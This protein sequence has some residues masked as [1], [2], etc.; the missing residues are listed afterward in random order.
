MSIENKKFVSSFF[1]KSENYLQTNNTK[2]PKSITKAELSKEVKSLESINVEVPDNIIQLV[3]KILRKK[4]TN[5]SNVKT[6]T[7]PIKDHTVAL[8]IWDFAGQ[9]AFLSTHQVS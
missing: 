6:N 4:G 7:T 5:Q 2:A 8:D 9:S 1:L 3:E